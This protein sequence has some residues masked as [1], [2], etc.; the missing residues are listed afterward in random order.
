MRRRYFKLFTFNLIEI[1][2]E[3]INI[4]SGRKSTDHLKQIPIT[5]GNITFGGNHYKINFA[6]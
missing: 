1:R 2:A 4:S 6:I 5:Q 3:L